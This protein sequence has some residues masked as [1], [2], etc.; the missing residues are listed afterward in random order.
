MNPRLLALAAGLAVGYVL[1][2]RAGR[3]KY[4]AMKAKVSAVWEDP[5]VARARR[6]VEEY[7]RAQ[8][9]IIRDRAEAAVK[10]APGVAKDVADRVS[11]T[12]KDVAGKVSTT[13]K[14]AAATA[15]ATAKDVGDR[16]ATTAKDVGDRVATT[17]RDVTE[18][19]TEAAGDARDQALHV[20][21]D[22]D[23]PR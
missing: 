13:A 5:R 2:T 16:V 11:S 15:T 4:D 9:P 17:A 1:G 14:D 12:A 23:A 21:E 3:E 7:A 22:D 10:A 8:A 19:V 20:M 18:R 6:E